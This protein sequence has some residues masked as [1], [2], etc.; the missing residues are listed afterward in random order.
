MSHHYSNLL[1]ISQQPWS[2]WNL[3]IT[4]NSSTK[5]KKLIKAKGNRIK[6]EKKSSP[7][8]LEVDPKWSDHAYLEAVIEGNEA[9]SEDMIF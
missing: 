3:T 2:M 9:W 6:K 5:E 7:P 8:Y 1:V 4:W